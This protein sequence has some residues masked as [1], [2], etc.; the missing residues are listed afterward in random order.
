MG[1]KDVLNPIALQYGVTP[2]EENGEEEN[3][4]ARDIRLGIIGGSRPTKIEE[5]SLEE[6]KQKNIEDFR[7]AEV[8]EEALRKD[9]DQYVGLNEQEKKYLIDKNLKGELKGA[10]FS[11]KKIL[12]T[13]N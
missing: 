5:L 7:Q 6:L 4:I 1:K 13:T 8:Q 2:K 11:K 10:D 3:P 12:I 9:L